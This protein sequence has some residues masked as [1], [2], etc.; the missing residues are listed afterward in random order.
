M[1]ISAHHILGGFVIEVLLTFL[2]VLFHANLDIVAYMFN[3]LYGIMLV[4]TYIYALKS[5]DDHYC[6]RLIVAVV[7]Y[8][9]LTRSYEALACLSLLSCLETVHSMLSTHFLYQ[10]TVSDFGRL[11]E[12]KKIVWWGWEWNYGNVVYLSILG[13]QV[14]VN[15]ISK[16]LLI[17]SLQYLSFVSLLRYC[18]STISSRLSVA[19]DGAEKLLVVTLIQGVFIR[20]LWLCEFTRPVYL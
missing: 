6:L 7:W 9:F 2:W 20:R 16:S 1:S 15:L 5:K 3:R 18:D 12:I 19:C 10:Y 14:L 13:V 4:Q 17:S 8:I 11:M